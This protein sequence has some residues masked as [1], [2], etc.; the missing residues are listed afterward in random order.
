[1]KVAL[2]ILAVLLV[3]ALLLGSSFVS[4]RNQ[5]AVKRE[6]VNAAWSQVDVVLQRRGGLFSQLWVTGEKDL[7]QEENAFWE[8]TQSRPALLLAKNPPAKNMAHKR[9]AS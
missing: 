5:M 7:V 2:G 3:I 6:A 8:N 9:L 1:M 4:H